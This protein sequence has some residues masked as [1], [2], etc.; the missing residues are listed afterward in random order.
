MKILVVGDDVVLPEGEHQVER[1]ASLAELPEGADFDLVYLTGA[2]EMVR[3]EQV[4]DSLAAVGP[5]LAELGELHVRVPSLEWACKEI[6]VTD[7]PKMLAYRW[8]YGTQ[9]RPHQ[10]GFTLLW[11]RMALINSGYNVRQATQLVVQVG[12]QQALEN[13]ALAIWRGHE[14]HA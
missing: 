9:E 4:V 3:R 10:S 13:Y 6:A 11:L 12:E 7:S 2:L 14:A 1:A 5:K 8:L